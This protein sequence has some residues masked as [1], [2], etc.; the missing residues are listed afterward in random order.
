M[1]GSTGSPRTP[2]RPRGIALVLGGRLIS[3]LGLGSAPVLLWQAGAGRPGLALIPLLV[4][5]GAVVL[6][7]ERLRA[8][9]RRRLVRD[10]P[11]PGPGELFVLYVRA[12]RPALRA[13]AAPPRPLPAARTAEEHLFD[14]LRDLGRVVA[15]GPADEEPPPAGAH[16]LVLPH[17]DRRRAVLDLMARARLVVISADTDAGTRWEFA[18]A[19]RVVPPERLLLVITPRRG[20]AHRTGTGCRAVAAP[21]TDVDGALRARAAELHQET[22]RAW[23]PPPL[24]A[25]PTPPGG[26]LGVVSFRAGWEPTCHV[27]A[28]PG[29][30]RAAALRRALAPAY[31]R[32]TAY[33]DGLTADPVVARRRRRGELIRVLGLGLV[34]FAV[35]RLAV[36]AWRLMRRDWD[37]GPGGCSLYVVVATLV[38]L[39]CGWGSARLGR[40]IALRAAAP[41]K[42]TP[43]PV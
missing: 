17:D 2:P 23:R 33:E 24:P 4:G 41:P 15:V 26:V 27:P 28:S 35:V 29:L 32:L 16:R 25:H 1:D 42:T 8:H 13:E 20:A 12:W 39:L 3:L 38:V 31:G 30:R 11:P 21:R 19:L 6:C 40:R 36:A 22:G 37:L 10:V 14:A 18:D 34:L 7:G 43:A 5:G 9:G